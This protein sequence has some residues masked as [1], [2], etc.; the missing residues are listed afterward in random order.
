ML[1]FVALVKPAYQMQIKRFEPLQKA[2]EVLEIARG[3]FD[4]VGQGLYPDGFELSRTGRSLK[5]STHG[6]VGG[7]IVPQQRPHTMIC[8]IRYDGDSEFQK[9]WQL[10]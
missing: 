5:P 8:R 2:V 10:V 1:D 4:R 7:P 6:L 3:G 9:S